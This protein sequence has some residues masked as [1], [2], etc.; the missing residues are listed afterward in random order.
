M[1]RLTIVGIAL[2]LMNSGAH[3]QDKP[4]RFWNLTV[5]TITALQMS[6]AGMDQWGIN[7]C[8]N[9][10]CAFALSKPGKVPFLPR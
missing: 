1:C 7:Q 4:I 8:K 10:L 3:A 9:A 5:Y 6:P 2:A